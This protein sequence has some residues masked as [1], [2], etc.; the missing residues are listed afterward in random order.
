MSPTVLRA[1][2]VLAAA[3]TLLPWL[4]APVGLALGAVF[5]LLLGNPFAKQTGTISG[6]LLKACV[7][8]LGFGLSISEVLATGA[9]GL[10]LTG[11]G[12]VL[13][14][15]AGLALARAFRVEDDAGRLV[16]S[17]TAICGGSAIAA[18]AP[19]LRAKPE[20]ISTAMACVFVLN[21]VA[22]YVFPVTGRLLD[23]TEHQFAVWAAIAIHD[24]S[25]VVGAASA[26]GPQALAEATVLKLARALWI[27][28]VVL[29]FAL[30]VARDDGQSRL[31]GFRPPLFI[32]LFVL[33]AAARS[34]L[35]SL[36]G[37]FDLL[38]LLA[39]QGLVLVLFLIGAGLSRELLS[40]VGWRPFAQGLVLWLATSVVSLL[41]VLRFAG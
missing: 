9:T 8:G 28:P 16:A 2:F 37:L 17:G 39:R 35:P 23:L 33:A 31:A 40:R 38:N 24:T 26:Y 41:A 34:L 20:A 4:T 7:V 30:L 6:Q 36:E 13:I 21:A 3:A 12:V 1:L 25:S 27:L 18:V 11:I 15:G 32:G 14:L 19:V 29:V 10:W 22:L 5:G